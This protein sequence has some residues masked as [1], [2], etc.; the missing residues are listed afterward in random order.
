MLSLARAWDDLPAGARAAIEEQWACVASGGLPCGA[1]IVGADGAV[2]ASGRNRAYDP[3]GPT[4]S[5]RRYPLQHN[6][7]AHAELNALAQ[8]ATEADHA[9][10]TLWSTQH[11]CLICASAARFAGVGKVCFIADDPS[12][13]TPETWGGRRERVARSSRRSNRTLKQL[14]GLPPPFHEA[15][16]L[17][18]ESS[19]MVVSWVGWCR[20]AI[21]PE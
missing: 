6:R 1:S 12:D 5:L 7:L 11:P 16:D 19:V 9:A 3:A 2:V 10:L 14:P 18:S 8:V 13:H 15:E 17:I 4:E 20:S 21:L